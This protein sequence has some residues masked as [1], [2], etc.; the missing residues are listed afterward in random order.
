MNREINTS[1][2]SVSQIMFRETKEFREG[3]PGV[4][5]I[6]FRQTA[7]KQ[8]YKSKNCV[9]FQSKINSWNASYH[10]AKI[11][12]YPSYFFYLLFES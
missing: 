7:Q 6:L 2:S 9:V 8:F 5:R 1:N 4:S 11:F 12:I 10:S 3:T